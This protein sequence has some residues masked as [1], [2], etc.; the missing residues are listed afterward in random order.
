MAVATAAVAALCWVGAMAVAVVRV[1]VV[2]RARAVARAVAGV[3]ARVVARAE[4][5]AVA[6]GCTIMIKRCIE[7]VARGHHNDGLCP[8]RVQEALS[9]VW[10]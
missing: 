9:M 2:A 5:R 8:N 10:G 6:R 7:I 4:A 1:R 3:V